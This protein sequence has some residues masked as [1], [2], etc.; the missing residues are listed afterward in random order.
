MHY[1]V[2]FVFSLYLGSNAHP[3]G[4]VIEEFKLEEAAVKVP[5]I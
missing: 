4:H 2:V 5:G 3:S 1:T